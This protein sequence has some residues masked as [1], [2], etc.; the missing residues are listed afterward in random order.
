MTPRQA[1]ISSAR[2]KASAVRRDLQLS[3]DEP[4][5]VFDAI[6][7]AGVWLVFQT[8][9]GI[10][11]VT[12]RTG[13]G[14]IIINPGR[15]LGMQRFT[16]AHEL[17]HWFL[18]EGDQWDDEDG[19]GGGGDIREAE[20]HAFASAFLMPRRLVNRT[21]RKYGVGRGEA[22]PPVVAYEASRDLGVSYL[23]LLVELEN[24]SVIS[25]PEHQR[26]SKIGVADLKRQ[27]TH[28]RRVRDQV[29]RASPSLSE[30]DVMVGDELVVDLEENPSTGYRWTLKDD[31]DGL[32]LLG[33]D[34]DPADDLTVGSGGT[35]RFLFRAA[36]EGRHEHHLALSR[37][38]LADAEP[39]RT[40]KVV[41]Y[42]APTPADFNRRILAPPITAP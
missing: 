13:H 3:D 27:L 25:R 38:W 1:R 4:V 17:G 40:A 6:R 10:L 18:H 15:P 31:V 21:L 36:S 28:G 23:A 33:D 30:L 37:A 9:D 8:M 34:Y 42:V 14:G 35:R 12:L 39:L 32:E 5:D 11:G 7:R 22:V 26:L 16:A 20:A 19:I 29:W 24:L 41:V 2:E